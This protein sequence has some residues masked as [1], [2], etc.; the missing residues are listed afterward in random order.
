MKGKKG[1]RMSGARA[2]LPPCGYVW[3]SLCFTL[4]QGM[5]NKKCVEIADLKKL[6]FR[7]NLDKIIRFECFQMRAFHPA[8]ASIRFAFHRRRLQVGKRTRALTDAPN[9]STQEQPND[10]NSD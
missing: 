9:T 7:F 1:D 4:P 10:P 6:F 3:S 8:S 5:L 2:P